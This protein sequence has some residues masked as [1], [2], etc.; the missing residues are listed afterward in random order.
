MQTIT[1]HIQLEEFN[2]TSIDMGDVGNKPLPSEY[3]DVNTYRFTDTYK[4]FLTHIL[5]R[6]SFPEF[7]YDFPVVV[8]KG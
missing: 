1:D 6:P 5:G 7:K 3:F 8:P 4:D 2:T